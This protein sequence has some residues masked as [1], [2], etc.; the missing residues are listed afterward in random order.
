M[1]S[2]F[3]LFI[4]STSFFLSNAQNVGIGTSAPT[5]KL[6]V[7]D[8]SVV[9]TATGIV[10]ASAGNPPVSGAGRRLM[11]YA[12]K[13]AFRAGY[14]PGDS[15]LKTSVGNYSFASGY[16][17]VAS[18]DF[19]AAVGLNTRAV[20]MA[21]LA[22]GSN[23]QAN[24]ETSTALGA[25]SFANGQSS[26]AIGFGNLAHGNFSTSIGY[27]N[28]AKALGSVTLGM[29]NDAYDN[30]NPADTAGSD[31]IFQI[32][33]GYY[34]ANIDDEVRRNAITVLRN[35][36]TG[37][38]TTTPA[39][40][41]ALEV[42][43]TS[44]G[45]LPPRM[46]AAQRTAIAAPAEGLLVYQTDGVSG[47]YYIKS[48]TW[49]ALTDAPAYPT[50]SVCGQQWMDK[51]LDVTSYRN[52]DPIPYVPNMA[53][54]ATLTT[55]AWCYFNNNPNHSPAHWGKLYNW[56][57]VN[58][59]R[60]LAPAGWHIATG[61]DW[62]SLINCLGDLAASGPAMKVTGALEW[63]NGNGASTN[64]SGFSAL[65]AG[66]RQS[67]GT[68]PFVG[69]STYFWRAEQ[70]SATNGFAFSLTNLST[71][72]GVVSVDKNYAFSVRCVKD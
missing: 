20:G 10:P 23:S 14:D 72:L 2:I 37:I 39:S 5:A 46:T 60:G 40:S 70:H 56:H 8:S 64:S 28:V 45:F 58:D 59:P 51:N 6:H 65:P 22:I 29:Y 49:T 67:N 12:D 34:D 7:A 57:A 47:Y 31:R 25:I 63:G 48:G 11:W 50:L 43:S 61:A 17:T 53:Q 15:W 27:N 38:G 32:G 71:A 24:A 26:T 1:K 68:F 4:L 42:S 9:F 66:S 18:G 3:T 33:N 41:A 13:A 21:S 52:G 44:K 55:G 36:N 69:P 19:A 62:Q 54:W 30:P 35:G 16:G